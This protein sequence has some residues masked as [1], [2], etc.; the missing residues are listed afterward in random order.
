[1]YKDKYVKL[2]PTELTI[3]HY[4]FPFATSKKILIS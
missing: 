1:M 4:H 3:Y 2:T